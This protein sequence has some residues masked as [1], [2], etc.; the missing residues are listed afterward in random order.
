MAV[1]RKGFEEPIKENDF[2]MA[3]AKFRRDKRV[4]ADAAKAKAQL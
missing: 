3:V 1:I 2:M 4:A